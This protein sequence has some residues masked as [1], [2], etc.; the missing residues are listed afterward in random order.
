MTPLKKLNSFLHRFMAYFLIRNYQWTRGLWTSFRRLKDVLVTLFSRF[1]LSFH[2]ILSMRRLRV[3][4]RPPCNRTS[5]VLTTPLRCSMSL[6]PLEY[7][8]PS[9][10]LGGR[11]LKKAV[12]L[13]PQVGW[14]KLLQDPSIVRYISNGLHWIFW[15]FRQILLDVTRKP[16]WRSISRKVFGVIPYLR[17]LIIAYMEI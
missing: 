9:E 7:Y 2:S 17:K 12:L 16:W 13:C 11:S 3:R 1:L 6:C 14:L 15:A 5:N 10:Y 4:R 8:L